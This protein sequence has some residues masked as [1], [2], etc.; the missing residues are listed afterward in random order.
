MVGADYKPGLSPESSQSRRF[1]YTG[2]EV[3]L[4]RMVEVI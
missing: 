4:G 1:L 2:F 3:S